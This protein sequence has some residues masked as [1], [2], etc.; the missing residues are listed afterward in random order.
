MNYLVE[1]M[2]VEL[3]AT[4]YAHRAL[5]T[6]GLLALAAVG[7]ERV[8]ITEGRLLGNTRWWAAVV[9]VEGQVFVVSTFV[10]PQYRTGPLVTLGP[11][12]SERLRQLALTLTPRHR[13]SNRDEVSPAPVATGRARQ[14]Q[15]E[16][17]SPRTVSLGVCCNVM[18]WP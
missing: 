8:V 7:V 5:F 17:R 10:A 2:A 13:K 3:H 15:M 1:G 14:A 9:Y 12:L 18:R 4:D 11:V 16:A 6:P